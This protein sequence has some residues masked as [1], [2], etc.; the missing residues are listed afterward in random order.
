MLYYCISA[1]SA[2]RNRIMTSLFGID[3]LRFV[4]HLFRAARMAAI[5][6][7]FRQVLH[8]VTVRAAVFVVGGLH[9]VARRMSALLQFG[10]RF[11]LTEPLSTSVPRVRAACR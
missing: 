8:V 10:H 6:C 7:Q 3:P 4:G 2:L 11:L 5:A 9:T 1:S